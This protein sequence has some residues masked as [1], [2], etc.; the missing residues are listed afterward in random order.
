LE[1]RW[2]VTIQNI[3]SL[4]AQEKVKISNAEQKRQ[5]RIGAIS[6]IRVSGMLLN[7]LSPSLIAIFSLIFLFYFQWK[8]GVFTAGLVFASTFLYLIVGR[9]TK[10]ISAGLIDDDDDSVQ[11]ESDDSSSMFERL[12]FI[13]NL[14]QLKARSKLIANFLFILF[15]SGLMF[16]ML[17]IPKDAEDVYELVVSC[18]LI[19]LCF[20]GIKVFG[21]KAVP[22]SRQYN[23]VKEF[24]S[25]PT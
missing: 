11:V 9:K 8:L 16:Y 4:I 23:Y 18:S 12:A 22:L 13:S 24:I 6:T 3:V 17:T 10:R 25:V 1:R 7:I 21:S 14:F 19:Y 5:I 15:V 20:N 2:F